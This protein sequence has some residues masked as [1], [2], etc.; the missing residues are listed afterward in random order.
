MGFVSRLVGYAVFAATLATVGLLSSCSATPRPNAAAASGA[1]TIAPD[2]SVAT[3][4]ASSASA[5]KPGSLVVMLTPGATLDAAIAAIAPDPPPLIE[6]TQWVY[7]L[8]FNKGDL[9]LLGIHPVELP[10]PQATP[11]AM[12]RFALELYSGPVLIERVRFD[13]PMMGGFD[14][15][16]DAG[17]AVPLHGGTFSFTAKLNTRV[18]VMFPA[19]NKGN[20]FVIWDRA[21]DR[22]W[23][24]PW[25]P[26]EM[27]VNADDAGAP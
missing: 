13:F 21:T 17:K 16:V 8:R 22:R 18:G 6:R 12:G 7:D 11:R 4:P 15:T 19:T 23:P 2:A 24:L 20:R 1:A 3:S 27:T 5:K 10:A 9:Y 25:P 14:H 26:S